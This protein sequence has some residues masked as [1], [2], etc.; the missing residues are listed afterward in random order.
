MKRNRERRPITFTLTLLDLC[1]CILG[2]L[3][4]LMILL[5]ARPQISPPGGEAV[6]RQAQLTVRIPALGLPSQPLEES[7]VK[8]DITRAAKSSNHNGRHLMTARTLHARVFLGFDHRPQTELMDLN[9]LLSGTVNRRTFPTS[10]GPLTVDVKRTP[11]IMCLGVFDAKGVGFHREAKGTEAHQNSI[12]EA[13]FSLILPEAEGEWMLLVELD[14]E[15]SDKA[16]ADPFVE[17]FWKKLRIGWEDLGIDPLFSL[18]LATTRDKVA[19]SGRMDTPDHFPQEFWAEVR[20]LPDDAVGYATLPHLMATWNG[21]EGRPGTQA[22]GLWLQWFDG[23]TKPIRWW[24]TSANSISKFQKLVEKPLMIK[25]GRF[26]LRYDV[27]NQ[28]TLTLPRFQLFAVGRVKLVRASD[29]SLVATVEH[30]GLAPICPCGLKACP[31]NEKL[32]KD[33]NQ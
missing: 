33:A 27:P 3:I 30:T 19:T 12:V 28:S 24:D 4:L 9:A 11:S 25:E 2:G 16:I 26:G 32:R 15:S 18:K 23:H 14:I 5:V 31:I 21:P 10:L 6:E 20:G 1:C 29:G 22:D 8:W 7:T 17:N 13:S